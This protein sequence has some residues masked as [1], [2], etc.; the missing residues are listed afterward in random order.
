MP[1]QLPPEPFPGIEWEKF[2]RDASA[3]LSAS[4]G[5][6]GQSAIVLINIDRF[7]LLNHSHGYRFA[8]S[9]LR[10]VAH[11]IR[12]TLG[13]AHLLS[14]RGGDE[15]VVLLRRLPNMAAAIDIAAA[16]LAEIARDIE[17]YDLV[18]SVTAS[19]G[20]GFQG[21]D[22]VDL[23]EL[24]NAADAGLAQAK[25]AGGNTYGLRS[26]SAA[27]EA[28]VRVRLRHHLSRGLDA[29]AFWIELQ[30]V[31]SIPARRVVSLETFVRWTDEALGAITPSEFI[32]IAERQGDL[33]HI[34]GWVL[35]QVIAFR[36]SARSRHL[37][38][39]PCSINLSSTEIGHPQMANT[40]IRRISEEGISPAEIEIE[41]SDLGH[42]DISFDLAD[43][44]DT[45]RAAGFR[46]TLDDFGSA[47]ASP[48][49]AGGQIGALKV[50]RRMTVEC[51]RDARA[52]SIVKSTVE[53]A[54][55]LGMDPIAEGVDTEAQL[56]WM[57]HL[58]F[59]GA[60]GHL[61]RRPMKVAQTLDWLHE[62]SPGRDRS[63]GSARP[64]AEF[65]R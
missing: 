21:R 58:G 65:A 3:A 37:N 24:L 20:V 4:A 52:L 19:A 18:A 62:T 32:P 2:T 9:A 5:G 17:A 51:M 47:M 50:D 30:P 57:G 15:F 38:A 49:L 46:I 1:D 23:E 16:I 12:A 60:Q 8:D 26:A 35:E 64:A 10:S 42:P 11:C 44:L 40:L 59:V 33:F 27:R 41:V 63:V 39:P 43:R 29:P 61:L 14:R 36:K 55:Q 45:L 56:V 48:L 22:G 53:L 31:F 7:R 13:T 54:R 25:S 34:G 6:P 28:D